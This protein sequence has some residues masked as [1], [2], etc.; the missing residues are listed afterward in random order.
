MATPLKQS[1]QAKRR[2]SAPALEKGL[3]I[4]ELLSNSRELNLTELAQKLN[5]TS[6][7]LYRVLMVLKDRGYIEY[8]TQQKTYHLSHKMF[9]LSHQ[10]A[11]LQR[12]TEAATDVIRSLAA[13]IDSSCHI[14][15]YSQGEAMAY[16]SYETPSRNRR[17]SIPS[18]G[19]CPLLTSAAGH[20]IWA[21]A[22]DED[23]HDMLATAS[24][25]GR[26]ELRNLTPELQTLAE[27]VFTDGHSCLPFETAPYLLDIAVP[28]FS[29]DSRL[30]AVLMTSD[31]LP[32]DDM[33]ITRHLNQL[34]TT[35][36][37]ISS[38]LGYVPG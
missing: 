12:L 2:Y 35:A 19:T 10:H 30:A 14:Y 16:L 9:R 17:V 37:Q 28:V 29:F 20:I 6:N 15:V 13:S 26:T 38:N 25:R 31:Y 18:G 22:S 5:R 32:P 23:R 34:K 27:T 8:S 1:S 3:D 4:I 7:E 33:R 21:F 24:A 36:A 11:P